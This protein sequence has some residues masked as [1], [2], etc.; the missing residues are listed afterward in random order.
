MESA[1]ATECGSPLVTR[2]LLVAEVIDDDG[3]KTLRIISSPDVTHWDRLGMLQVAPARA[4][5]RLGGDQ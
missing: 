2:W 5:A 1:I 3:A 4:H